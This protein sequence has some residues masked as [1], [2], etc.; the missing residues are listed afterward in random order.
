MKTYLIGIDIGTSGCKIAVF[1]KAGEVLAAQSGTYP[2]YYPKPGWAEQN[3]EDWWNTICQVLPE[4]L[5]KAEIS[6]DEIAGI[7]IDGQSWSAIAVDENGNVLTNTPIWMDTRAQNICDELN[8]RIGKDRIF[9][10]CG[11]S[12]QPSYTTPKIVWYQRNLPE[13]YVKTAKILQSNSYIAF[14]LTGKMTQD[15]SQGYGLHCFNMQEMT[16]DFAMCEELGFSKDLLP[17]IYPCHAVIGTVTEEA[18]KESGL[19]VGIPVVAGGLDAACGALGV[20]VLHDGETQEQGG[21]AGGMS[22]CMDHYCADERLI[23]GAHVVPGHWLLQG[24]NYRRRRCHALAGKGIWRLGTR[25]RKAKGRQLS[26]SDERRGKSNS[27][28]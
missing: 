10:L 14:K 19:C 27:G 6:P 13:V 17:E 7:G 23:L 11:N 1:N 26:G 16:W 2:V 24:G 9:K 21:Q 25:G 3:P 12:L 5:K 15:V 18:A 22:I 8:E 4:M 20:G 28:G